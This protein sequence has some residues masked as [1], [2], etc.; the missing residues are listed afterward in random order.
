[1]TTATFHDAVQLELNRILARARKPWPEPN[2]F[3][4]R[5]GP[6]VH[7][8]FSIDFPGDQPNRLFSADWL[9]RGNAAG[10]YEGVRIIGAG[11]G[12]THIADSPGY[13]DSTIFGAAF[14]GV[15]Q[16]E[17]LT[18]H[19]SQRKAIHLG[20]EKTFLRYPK[21]R[22]RFRDVHMVADPPGPDGMRAVWGATG[23]GLDWDWE[24]SVIN[25]EEGT[26]HG[27]YGRGWARRGGRYVRCHFAGSGAEGSKDASR[28]SEVPFPGL[29]LPITYYAD[30]TFE[31]WNKPH[32]WRGGAGST[33]QGSIAHNVYERCIFYGGSDASH[34]R[35]LMVDDG[36]AADHWGINGVRG[37]YPSNG[38]LIVHACAFGGRGTQGTSS[39]LL[40]V[41]PLDPTM[42][43]TSKGVWIKGSA[44]YGQYT[45]L[46]LS[47]VPAGRILVEGNNTARIRQRAAL[48]GI[49][50]SFETTIPTQ[51]RAV[52]VSEGYSL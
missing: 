13:Q 37:A 29:P 35:C 22:L 7:Q 20:L 16:L 41:G 33:K 23:Y 5:L 19:G 9:T 24:D 45:Q 39:P 32:T 26:E 3:E 25:W 48:L 6:G 8:G 11:R 46:Q 50:T 30:C 51:H 12:L 1:M 14:N 36:G 2:L 47:N 31:N 18:I 34:S 21:F 28:P 52:P 44:F 15:V 4:I 17:S 49:D 40:R 43:P 42:A 27:R 10:P 38:W